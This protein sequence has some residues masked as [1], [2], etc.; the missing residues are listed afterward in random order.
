MVLT[1]PTP[2][3]EAFMTQNMVPGPLTNSPQPPAGPLPNRVVVTVS[4]VLPKPPEE[5]VLGELPRVPRKCASQGPR[6]A[7][8]KTPISQRLHKRGRMEKIGDVK[9]V[10][11]QGAGKSGKRSKMKSVEER[12]KRVCS[13]GPPGSKAIFKA[14]NRV[15]LDDVEYIAARAAECMDVASISSPAWTREGPAAATVTVNVPVAVDRPGEV[16]ALV[17]V[18]GAVALIASAEEA[19]ERTAAHLSASASAAA[20]AAAVRMPKGGSESEVAE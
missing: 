17:S 4:D 20:V 3:E 7:L 11:K 18:D 16:D 13:E 5:S 2:P 6:Q 12:N 14:T 10:W 9:N 1:A 8:K 15:Y 19:T